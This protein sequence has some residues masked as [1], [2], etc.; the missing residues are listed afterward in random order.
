MPLRTVKYNTTGGVTSENQTPIDKERALVILSHLLV[1]VG[2]DDI[3]T[4]YLHLIN[5]DGTST[6]II[7]ADE[8]PDT[9]KV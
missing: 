9:F 5:K 8:F 4:C 3:K 2:G 6:T 7:V 1:G